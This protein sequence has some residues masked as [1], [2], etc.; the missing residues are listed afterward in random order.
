MR[1][2]RLND[3]RRLESSTTEALF[4]AEAD[5]RSVFW[6]DVDAAGLASLGGLLTRL[7]LH[8]LVLDGC[9]DPGA[10]PSVASYPRSLFVRVPIQQRWDD[11][12]NDYLALICL[13]RVL[14]TVHAG[15]AP[16][17][18]TLVAMYGDTLRFREPTVAALLYQV[19]DLVVDQGMA[20]AMA[21]RRELDR[22]QAAAGDD[23][24]PILAV[25]RLK[26]AVSHLED[27]LEDLRL[28]L[29]N[30]LAVQTEDFEVGE[31]RVYYRDT[32]AHIESAL[33][34]IDRQQ[35]RLGE[36]HQLFLLM[37]QDK[38]NRRLRIL[39]ILSA[40]FMPLTLISGI[41]GM[42]FRRM[43]ELDQPWGYPAV[44]LAMVGIAGLLLA[45]FYRRGW[46]D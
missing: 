44:L 22:V 33:A 16:A 42:N 14:I 10:S 46:F 8:P 4:A 2:Y 27:I 31:L 23:T 5:G 19:I 11:P 12:A 34:S 17:L 3:D 45:N 20:F 32:L 24:D 43:P 37:L 35:S 15:E 1:V 18:H 41:Y 30:L 7:Q 36:L 39:T 28:S 29:G 26:Q 40:V 25:S 9:L 13:R 38:T 6:V 21:S